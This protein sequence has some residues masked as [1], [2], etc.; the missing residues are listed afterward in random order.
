MN[1]IRAEIKRWFRNAECIPHGKSDE[2]AE[3]VT[4]YTEYWEGNRTEN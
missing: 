2:F 3:L 4:E 1:E